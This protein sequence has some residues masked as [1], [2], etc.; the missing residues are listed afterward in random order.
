MYVSYDLCSDFIEYVIDWNAVISYDFSQARKDLQIAITLEELDETINAFYKCDKKEIIDGVGDV[1]VTAGFYLYLQNNQNTEFLDQLYPID[2][3][4]LKSQVS[5]IDLLHVIRDKLDIEK[6][7]DYF[8]LQL[9]CAHTIAMFG[10]EVVED[11]FDAILKSNDSKFIRIDE[12]DE[13]VE[14]NH[15]TS[16][17]ADKFSDITPVT[18]NFRGTEVILL[19]ADGGSGKLL[20][21]TTFKEPDEFRTV[22]L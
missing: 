7:V 6:H 13:A 19:R 3:E 10:R 22:P 17:Y 14:M 9:L 11:Y 18:R 8:E 15:V 5:F 2:S 1:L 4:P 21:P 16:K 20:K 12:Y